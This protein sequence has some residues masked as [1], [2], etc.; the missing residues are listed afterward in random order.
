MEAD[1]TC[2]NWAIVAPPME[3]I[4]IDLGGTKTEIA[5][6]DEG[7]GE[8]LRRR[9]DTPAGDYAAILGTIEALV[10]DAERE[11]GTRCTVGVAMPG[12][13]SLA[14][15]LVKNAN[16]TC[17]I[18]R[19]FRQDLQARLGREVRLAN[20]ANCF[21]LSEAVDGAGRG[22]RTVFGVILGSRA[23]SR[24]RS[25]AVT[26]AAK[27]ASRRS[28]PGR[29]SPRTTSAPPASACRRPRS[30]AARGK[31][32]RPARRRSRATRK[33]SRAHSRSS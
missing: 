12:A 8:V 13:L 26:A 17:L 23:R 10:N 31:A 5:V 24:A 29:G 33:G 9:V 1:F 16:S 25:R 28:C 27:A 4:G 21:A 22:A 3:R 6:L 2:N 15:G 11:R 32:T 7:G 18:G 19:P 30:R 20:D 14:T